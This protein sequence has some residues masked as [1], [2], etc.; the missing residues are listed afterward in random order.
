MPGKGLAVGPHYIDYMVTRLEDRNE[1]LEWNVY[2]LP[3]APEHLRRHFHPPQYPPRHS[4]ELFL[5]WI[6]NP[7]TGEAALERQAIQIGE[8]RHPCVNRIEC[9][10]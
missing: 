10:D 1:V 5:Q 2:K 6:F 4:V 3:P 8:L 9:D 7:Q